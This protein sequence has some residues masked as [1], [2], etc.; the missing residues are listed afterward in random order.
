VIFVDSTVP[1]YLVGTPQPNEARAQALL[2]TA[3]ADRERLVT[4]AK[5]LREIMHRFSAIERLDAV[6]PRFDA[7]LRVVDDVYPVELVDVERGKTVLLCGLGLS[8]RDALYIAVRQRRGVGETMS[9]DGDFDLLPRRCRGLMY[10]P[11]YA[12]KAALPG[13]GDRSRAQ[14]SR[15]TNRAVGGVARAQGARSLS[16]ADIAREWRRSSGAADRARR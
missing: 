8:A 7:L 3:I 16:G 1:M 4:D 11:M 12:Q 10:T 5:V 2:E 15:R 9:F 6:Q 14:A 13:R